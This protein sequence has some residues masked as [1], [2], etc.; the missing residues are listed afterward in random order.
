MDYRTCCVVGVG[1]SAER[2]TKFKMA[3]S[4]CCLLLTLLIYTRT[5][6]H[7]PQAFRKT[8]CGA[9][10]VVHRLP[11]GVL[12]ARQSPG[13]LHRRHRPACQCYGYVSEMAVQGKQK[14]KTLLEL[15]RNL[16]SRLRQNQSAFFSS[17]LG[18][19][20]HEVC[21]HRAI[22]LCASLREVL[23]RTA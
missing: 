5:H 21:C 17:L 2:E 12:K 9:M 10:V 3:F 4:F 23:K 1:A 15:T 22:Y 18:S 8:R 6:T 19:L 11:F 7:T 20:V 16:R 13:N 14:Q